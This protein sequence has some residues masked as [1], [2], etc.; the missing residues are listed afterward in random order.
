MADAGWGGTGDTEPRKVTVS[1]QLG[2]SRVQFGFKVRNTVVGIKTDQEIA[3]E[4]QTFMGTNLRGLLGENDSLLGVDVL[5]MATGSGGSVSWANTKGTLNTSSNVLTL[6]SYMCAVVTAK[7]SL[8]RRYGQGRFF[9][10]VRLENQVDNDVLSG[11]GVSQ[12]QGF[13]TAFQDAFVMNTDT[14]PGLNMINAHGVIPPKAA[15]STSPARPEVPP[16][17]YD[18]TTLRLNNVV[19]FLRSRKAGVGS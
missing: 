17:W 7:S 10:P 4:V 6:P 3:E 9:L 2:L 18:V 14:L 11:L 8:R 19:T 1:M 15:T 12:L 13:L 5:N 16:H